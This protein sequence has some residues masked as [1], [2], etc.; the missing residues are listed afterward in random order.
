MDIY[1]SIPNDFAKA[2]NEQDIEQALKLNFIIDQYRQ[3][4]VGLKDAYRFLNMNELDFLTACNERGVSRQ[5]Y[6]DEQELALEFYQ[7]SKHYTP[8]SINL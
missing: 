7:L 8:K 5:T 6:V 2:M 3:G 1:I 4:N